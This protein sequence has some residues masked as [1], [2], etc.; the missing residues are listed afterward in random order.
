MGSFCPKHMFQ[1]GISEELYVM[2][3]KGITTVNG[4]MTCGLKKDKRKLVNIH[5]ICQ[6]FENLHFDRILFFKVYKDLDST[7][8]YRRV[9]S[10]DTEE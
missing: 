3:L 1:L 6:K 10:H 2:T 4:K 7:E 8:E 9:M 5:V